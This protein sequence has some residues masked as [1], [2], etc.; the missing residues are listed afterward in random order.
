MTAWTA[1]RNH[2]T[3]FAGTRQREFD[4]A[5]SAANTNAQNCARRPAAPM[6]TNVSNRSIG[7]VALTGIAARSMPAAQNRASAIA[8]EERGHREEKHPQERHREPPQGGGERRPQHDG[9]IRRDRAPLAEQEDREAT[10][11]GR[12]ESPGV[13]Q[14]VD[15]EAHVADAVTPVRPERSPRDDHHGIRPEG[16]AAAPPSPGVDEQ[17]VGGQVGARPDPLFLREQGGQE[18]QRG[19]QPG[20]TRAVSPRSVVG[21]QGRDA[22]GRRHEGVAVGQETDGR[23]ARVVHREEQGRDARDPRRAEHPPVEAA[24]TATAAPSQNRLWACISTG[25]S[26]QSA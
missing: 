12:Q 7:N 13:G 5:S 17:R 10:R 11:R 6:P 8:A 21:D 26:G 25:E 20:G 15:V 18:Q 24:V 9:E 19:Q 4:G 16:Q 22:E 23:A 14:R 1:T 2:A 3:A